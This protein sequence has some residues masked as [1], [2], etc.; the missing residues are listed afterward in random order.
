VKAEVDEGARL[1]LAQPMPDPA[2]AVEGVFADQWEP[3]GDGNA[4]WSRWHDAAAV[5]GNGRV[6]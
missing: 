2:E 3:L 4:P 5:N 1:A 6:A